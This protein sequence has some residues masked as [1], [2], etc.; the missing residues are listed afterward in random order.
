M[1]EKFEIAVWLIVVTVGI[2]LIY[3][4]VGGVITYGNADDPYPLG[5]HHGPQD[6]ITTDR[7]R[8]QP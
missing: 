1:K 4:F 3:N 2:Y 7:S 5:I 6:A 8:T